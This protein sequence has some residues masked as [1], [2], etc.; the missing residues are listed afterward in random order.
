MQNRYWM[1][2][3]SC[4]A[5]MK[6]LGLICRLQIR[7]TPT[8]RGNL[9]TW[10]ISTAVIRN[11]VK[12]AL[13]TCMHTHIN[14]TLFHQST[15]QGEKWERIIERNAHEQE[16]S[17]VVYCGKGMGLYVNEQFCACNYTARVSLCTC[18]SRKYMIPR[19]ASILKDLLA[20]GTNT[21][22]KD[23]EK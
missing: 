4:R 7:C 21:I 19:G 9:Q 16:K 12:N 1:V 2:D 5:S 22:N 23:V 11:M 10:T 18:T 17:S 8:N 6:F 15:G 3:F 13:K 20:V 14:Y